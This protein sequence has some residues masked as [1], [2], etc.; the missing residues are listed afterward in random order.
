MVECAKDAK[1]GV[2]SFF[3]A[4]PFTEA[5]LFAAGMKVKPAAAGLSLLDVVAD[6]ALDALL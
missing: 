2:L 1:T 6:A 5:S 4:A 3:S